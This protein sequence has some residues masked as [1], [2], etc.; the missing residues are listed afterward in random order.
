M[1]RAGLTTGVAGIALLASAHVA[2]QDAPQGRQAD[3]PIRVQIEAVPATPSPEAQVRTLVRRSVRLLD[4]RDYEEA[5]EVLDAAIAI[6]PADVWA[7]AN[8]GMALAH[9]RQHGEAEESFKRADSLAPENA[10]VL[11]GRGL[12]ALQ[13]RRHLAAENYF[14]RSLE[15]D[16]GSSFAL[17][18]RAQANSAQERPELA[19][20]DVDAAI[21]QAPGW[22]EPYT[23]R[24]WLLL[25][26][27]RRDDAFAAIDAML[28]I[29]PDNAFA[30]A[31]AADLLDRAGE[32]ERADALLANSIAGGETHLAL[33]STAMMR[34]P[35]ETAIKLQELNRA[36][37]LMPQ[38]L[39]ALHA[40]AETLW[41]EYRLRDALADVDR[42]II[43]EP[44]FWPGH[45][46]RGRILADLGR[47]DDVA[48]AA[49][50]LAQRF[51]FEPDALATASSL[52]S[53]AGDSARADEME[54][55]LRGLEPEHPMLQMSQQGPRQIMVEPF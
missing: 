28:E 20:A 16:A 29:F 30:Q 54:Q 7:W 5:I 43:I 39:P 1:I 12:V 3:L 11:R 18:H 19:L 24:A 14:T 31:V 33:F 2:A 35:S 6:D 13:Q 40:R 50:D 44:R 32:H 52:F 17:F 10:V 47:E 48:A 9:L 36:L 25:A 49:S 42:S 27:E 55:A 26:M 37:D 15:R 8:R 41:A 21:A 46:L 38:F 34:P 22:L 45:L 23:F 51:A 53:L 4:S